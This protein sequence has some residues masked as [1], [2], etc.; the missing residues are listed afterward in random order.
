MDLLNQE[1]NME[2]R[3]TLAA[4]SEGM[5][6]AV[7]KAG[8]SVVRVHGRRRRPGSGVVYAEDLVLTAGHVLE[9]EEDLSVETADGRTLAARFVGRDHSSDLAVL[10]VEGLGVEAATPAE[11]EARVGQIS[12]AVASP[13][14]GEG[15]RATFGIVSSVGGPVKT[16]RGPRLER[17][18]QTDASPY[19]GLSGGP[20]VDVDGDVVGVMVAGWGRGAAFAVPADLAWRVAGTLKERGT[21]KQGYLGILSQPVR[22]PDGGRLGLTQKGGLL[23]VGVEDGS[24]ADQGGLMVGDIVATL[25]GQPAEDTDDLLVLLSGERV[26]RSVPVKVVRGGEPQELNVTVGERG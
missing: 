21:V 16:R 17:Y 3:E 23:V 1:K 13:G 22:L 7:A 14:R 26:G 25:D 20:L 9:R 24:P 19:P 8:R 18:I 6:D 10:R 2:S 12:L 15:P 4:L 11:G 5:A